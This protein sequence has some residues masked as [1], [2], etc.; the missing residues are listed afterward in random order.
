MFRK[1]ERFSLSERTANF[2]VLFLLSSVELTFFDSF[3]NAQ[4]SNTLREQKPFST[5]V[6]AVEKRVHLSAGENE[7]KKASALTG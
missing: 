4:I 5:L 2:R 6:S 3:I 7:P 1:N